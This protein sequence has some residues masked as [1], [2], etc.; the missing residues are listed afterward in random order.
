MRARIVDAAVRLRPHL[1]GA[2]VAFHVV[3]VLLLASPALQGAAMSK[4]AWRDPSVQA[5]FKIWGPRVRAAGLDVTDDELLERLYATSMV[6]MDVRSEVLRPFRP[7]AR[8]TG[9]TQNWQLF[10]A[11]QVWISVMHVDAELD[12]AWRTLFVD[13]DPAWR[14]NARKLEADRMQ[15]LLFWLGFQDRKADMK[16]FTQWC[17]VE[18]ARDFPTAT[19]VRARFYKT[20][21]PSPE[22][23]A[24]GVVHDGRFVKEVVLDVPRS[25]P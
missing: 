3:A 22:E 2:F 17:A 11:P 21:S 6:F 18:V 4:K 9:T 25:A 1:V 7:Y 19:R 5:E 20:K 8:A 24:R 15:S 13:N 16:A 12:G 14:W 10:V 23:A